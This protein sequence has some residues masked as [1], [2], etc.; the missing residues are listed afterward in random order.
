M[1]PPARRQSWARATIRGANES[2]ANVAR[3]HTETAE[4]LCECADRSC[5]RRITLTL[6]EYETVRSSPGGLLLAPEHRPLRDQY[7]GGANESA[8]TD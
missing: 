6:A 2:I 4:F 1:R 8:D 7:H 3:G 5:E